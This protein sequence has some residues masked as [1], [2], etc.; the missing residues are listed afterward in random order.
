MTEKKCTYCGHIIDENE[1]IC[2]A[3]HKDLN[4]KCPY[5]KQEIKVY[6]DI[7]PYCTTKLQKNNKSKYTLP[8]GYA[9][10]II[11]LIINS[12]ELYLIYKYPSILTMKDKHGN[13]QFGTEEYSDL[14][15]SGLIGTLV[16]YIIAIVTN[17]KKQIAIICMIINVIITICFLC[18]FIYL[19][20]L[21]VS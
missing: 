16:P 21:Y 1:D 9:L 10:S 3:C 20:N 4:I 8:I 18:Y 19:K 2:P 14:L 12:V 17:Y 6:D 7:C 11:W 5:C 15:L 13:Y